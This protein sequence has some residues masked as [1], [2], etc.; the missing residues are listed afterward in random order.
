MRAWIV[1]TLTLSVP[2]LGVLTSA[3]APGATAT[4]APKG[5]AENGKKI[6]A[7]YGCYQCHNYAANGGGAGPRLAPRPIP[8]AAFSAYVRAPKDQMPPYT[9]KSLSDQELAD[10]YAHLLTIPAPPAVDAI[11]ILKP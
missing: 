10:I 9:V 3:Q 7:S 11:P 1:L 4:P 2:A 5:N 8:F 6:F